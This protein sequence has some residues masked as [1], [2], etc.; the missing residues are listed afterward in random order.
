MDVLVLFGAV[1]AAVAAL[2]AEALSKHIG[3][4]SLITGSTG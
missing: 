4:T 3:F 2:E 1:G